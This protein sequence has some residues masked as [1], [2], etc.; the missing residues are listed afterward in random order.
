MGSLARGETFSQ[1]QWVPICMSMHVRVCLC[2]QCVLVVLNAFVCAYMCILS[3]MLSCA[4][5][6]VDIQLSYSN[7]G[8][9]LVGPGQPF[10]HYYY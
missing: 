7:K 3:I 6:P 1:S 8:T 9:V 4:K 2:E 5:V 10:T